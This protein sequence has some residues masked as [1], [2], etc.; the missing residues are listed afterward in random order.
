LRYEHQQFLLPQV[1]HVTPQQEYYLIIAEENLFHPEEEYL[2]GD[3]I[4]Q[5]G[6]QEYH[7]HGNKE[8]FFLWQGIK[9]YYWK[10]SFLTSTVTVYSVP[11]QDIRSTRM[12]L[13]DRGLEQFLGFEAYLGPLPEKQI[14]SVVL[15]Y[16]PNQDINQVFTQ[17]VTLGSPELS[18]QYQYHQDTLLTTGEGKDQVITA[19]FTGYVS[20]VTLHPPFNAIR[21]VLQIKY[22]DL[23]PPLI[24]GPDTLYKAEEWVFNA[25]EVL[26]DYLITDNSGGAVTATVEAIVNGYLVT[27]TDASGNTTTKTIQI[28]CI[29]PSLL[30]S[31]P[32]TV[33]LTT[34]DG[35]VSASTIGKK[36]TARKPLVIDNIRH[37]VGHPDRAYK[38][39]VVGTYELLFHV[40]FVD[41]ST[42]VSVTIKVIIDAYRPLEF[43]VKSVVVQTSQSVRLSPSAIKEKLYNIIKGE[44]T[45]IQEINLTYNE[46][47]G[48]ENTPGQYRVDYAVT[49]AEQTYNAK[50]LIEVNS[51][52]ST[53]ATPNLALIIGLT[54]GGGVVVF[55]VWRMLKKKR[56]Y[57]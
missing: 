51:D 26:E 32:E 3:F 54:V 22:E 5:E 28:Y 9:C 1:L 57:R 49:T 56:V 16:V 20:P 40:F 45:D 53:T 29:T 25:T 15:P 39:G 43:T 8:Q 2:Y 23:L 52:G 21:L 41:N 10:M 27:A 42:P 34:N 35:E 6:N 33:Y 55:V 48:N 4:Y 17:S 47:E 44:V 38:P 14:I 36:I 7:I 11:L 31:F 46:Y 19:F 12:I 13:Q 30:I 24:T 37:I 18:M 50:A